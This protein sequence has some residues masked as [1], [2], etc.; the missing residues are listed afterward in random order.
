MARVLRESSGSMQGSEYGDK[1][2]RAQGKPAA[3][4]CG[5]AEAAGLSNSKERA[6][7]ATRA[8]LFDD[9]SGQWWRLEF[10]GATV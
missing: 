3:M 6:H 7:G 5:L 1:G 9:G 10:N 2:G 4:M 8:G